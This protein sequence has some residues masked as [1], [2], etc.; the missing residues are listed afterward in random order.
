MILSCIYAEHLWSD[1]IKAWKEKMV[2]K[3]GIMVS[4]LDDAI[5]WFSTPE[6]VELNGS[7]HVLF[8]VIDSHHK[9]CSLRVKVCSTG[10][11]EIN[12]KKKALLDAAKSESTKLS[13]PL[14]MDLIDKQNNAF[15]LRTFDIDVEEFMDSN[16]YNTTEAL[17]C[18]L[19]RNWYRAED[20]PGLSAA[21][22]CIMRVQFLNWLNGV[23]NKSLSKFPP[24][25]KYVAGIPAVLWEGLVLSIERK[26]QLYPYCS[27]GSYNAR[28]T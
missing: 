12:I 11:P 8:N 26:I 5:N 2:L 27:R 28:A 7:Q 16:G 4:A 24:P 13:L 21:E 15:A 20:E 10:I 19:I 6:V 17:L 14:V 22:R 3:D 9:L 1:W 25:G 18:R 23:G